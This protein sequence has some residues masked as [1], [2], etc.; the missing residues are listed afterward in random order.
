MLVKSRIR[1]TTIQRLC[2]HDGPGVRTVV[3]LK[4]CYL[5]CP[6]CC[7][8]ETICYDKDYLF[9]KGICKKDR[10]SIICKNC[11]IIGG[12]RPEIECPIGAFEK[13]FTEYEIDELYTLLMRDKNL[14]SNG[15]GITFSGGDP[16][17]QAGNLLP[18]LEKLKKEKI[19]IAIETSLYA[20]AS[21]L[22]LIIPY[23]NYWIVDLKFQYGYI[24]NP[25]SNTININPH[26]N[27]ELLQ[28]TITAN[29]ICYR[30][31][32]MREILGSFNKV[33]EKLKSSYIE[34]IELL[35]YHRLGENK[36]NEL[37]KLFRKFHSL[38]STELNNCVKRLTDCRIKA[39]FLTI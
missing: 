14:Y 16:L 2:I 23:I 30:M 3:F 26:N 19:H 24:I 13:T 21:N 25:N 8:P 37:R 11:R 35:N 28:S 5:Q 9:D 33:I 12:N 15:G 18:L 4:G 6:W 22:K 32:V 7:N 31:V 20:P 10:N 38:S 17:Y 34:Q 36:Y 29:N 27:L 1:V 39:S